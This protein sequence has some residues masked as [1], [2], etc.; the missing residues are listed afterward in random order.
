MTDYKPRDR[1]KSASEKFDFS[2]LRRPF[3]AFILLF[4][5]SLTARAFLQDGPLTGQSVFWSAALAF[6]MTVIQEFFKRRAK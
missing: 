3:I 1:E 6:G 5:I 4:I 2:A